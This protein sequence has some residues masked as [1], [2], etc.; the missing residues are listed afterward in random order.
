MRSGVSIM[1]HRRVLVGRAALAAR[2]PRGRCRPGAGTFGSRIGVGPGRGGGGQVGLAPLGVH[3][4]DADHDLPLA[5]TAGVDRRGD[6]LAGLGLGFGRDRILQVEDDGVR[7]QLRAFS[8][9]RA[10]EPGM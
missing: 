9:A 2:A 5:E 3:A 4:V 1:A 7:W 10:L 6:L 8:I